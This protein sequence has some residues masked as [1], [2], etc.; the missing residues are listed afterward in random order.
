VILS[1][2]DL[3]VMQK[4]VA[5]ARPEGKDDRQDAAAGQ[6]GTGPGPTPPESLPASEPA[7]D[8]QVW[9]VLYDGGMSL[10]TD[11]ERIVRGLAEAERQG[12]RHVTVRR[13]DDVQTHPRGVEKPARPSGRA[14][15]KGPVR[16]GG[17]DKPSVS[18]PGKAMGGAD[19]APE[20]AA[21]RRLNE[22]RARRHRRLLLYALA[23][24]SIVVAAVVS[25]HWG[26]LPRVG[27]NTGSSPAQV[28]GPAHRGQLL[29][30][31][32]QPPVMRFSSA[33]G[34]ASV[35]PA[36]PS[37]RAAAEPSGGQNPAA[38]PTGPPTSAES[39][40]SATA[41]SSGGGPSTIA[42]GG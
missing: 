40:Q 31:L 4:A 9:A 25:D 30:P 7:S 22:N 42:R 5:A 15:G 36:A 6:H 18:G 24:A 10:T 29:P 32:G 38:Q 27:A 13:L 16:P 21:V 39:P 28:D 11:S 34:S 35:G 14:R 41:K 17:S 12:G 3:A 1:D 23:A 2:D 37:A 33:V 20:P 8:G 26:V 19:R